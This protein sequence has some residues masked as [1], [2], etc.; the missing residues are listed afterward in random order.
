[1]ARGN[2]PTTSTALLLRLVV[3]RHR[4]SAMTVDSR[5]TMSA[6]TRLLTRAWNASDITPTLLCSPNSSA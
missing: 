1:M 3:Y 6:M 5:A 2:I 4:N